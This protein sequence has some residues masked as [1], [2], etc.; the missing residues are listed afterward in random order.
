[1]KIL[2]ITHFFPPGHVGG[3]EVLTFGLARSLQA[4]GHTVRV[5]CAE[6]WDSAPSFK[7]RATDEVVQGIPVRRLRFNWA[8]A[9]D[10][11]RYLYNNPETEEHV[12]RLIQEFQPDVAHV[13]SCY[14]L[15]AS[16]ISAVRRSALPLVISATDFWFLC[17]R[18]T[19]LRSDGSLCPG[20]Q[21]EYECARCMLRDAKFYRW[22]SQVLPQPV[23]AALLRAVG[24][25]PALTNRPGLRGMHGNWQERFS[26]LAGALGQADYIT[27]ASRFLRNLF[28]EY[29]VPPEKITFSAYGLDTSWAKGHEV[30]TPSADLRV[31]F[32]GQIIPEKGPDL[33][34]EA[35]KSLPR[36][37]PLQVKLYGALDKTPALGQRLRE[38]AQG[39]PRIQFLGTFDN[40][41]MGE[42]LSGMDILAVPSTWY[43]FPLVISSALA[44][45]TP[46]VATDLPG[47]NE[48][49]EHNRNGLLFERG[50]WRGLAAQIERLVREPGLIESL[51]AGIGPVKTLEQMARE[52]EAVYADLTAR[53]G[54][55]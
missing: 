49:I 45:R 34:L 36:E 22:P 15:S 33:L 21:S 44:T 42:V 17:A 6:D 14:S 20:P 10:V 13:T 11:F 5:V 28:I 46:V 43:D 27:T 19:L 35:I 23:V 55:R 29:G 25:V 50:D 9:P 51:R 2:L 1:M 8:L 40:S 32:I 47:M 41:R 26:F 24:R 16:V 48:L 39:D 3:T 12:A 37:T 53:P 38:M 18:D 7:I 31:G 30:K 52:Y 4:C 54:S